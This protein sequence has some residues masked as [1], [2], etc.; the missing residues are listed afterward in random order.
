MSI[1]SII[2]GAFNNVMITGNDIIST[3]IT[4]YR[5][6]THKLSENNN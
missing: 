4:Q 1:L 5:Y 2:N 6:I 3:L